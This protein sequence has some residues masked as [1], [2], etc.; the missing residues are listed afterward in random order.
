MASAFDAVLPAYVLPRENGGEA[1]LGLVTSCAGIAMLAGSL[2][3]AAAP[4]PKNPIKVI[5]LTMLFSLS[6]ENFLLAFCQTPWLWCLGQVLGWLPVPLMS[7]NLDVTLRTRIPVEMQGRVYSCR[8]TLQFFTIPVGFFLGGWMVDEIWEPM[9]AQAPAN[10]L[11]AALFGI[12]K[13]S[14]ASVMMLLLGILGTGICLL[15]GRILK[16]YR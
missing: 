3:A 1:V 14:G 4:A 9:M 6:T 16:K 15:F 2:I 10:G 13:G 7:A 12:G 5:Y 11:T 8:N